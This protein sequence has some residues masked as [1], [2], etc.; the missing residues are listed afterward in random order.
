MPRLDTTDASLATFYLSYLLDVIPMVCT[1]I[2]SLRG[3]VLEFTLGYKSELEL[4]M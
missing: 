2:A 3:T 4:K 1:S